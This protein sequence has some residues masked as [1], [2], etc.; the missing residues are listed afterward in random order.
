MQAGGV[1]GLY[2]HWKDRASEAR[3]CG[4][5]G[6]VTQSCHKSC[7][8]TPWPVARQTPLSM[9]FF[10]QEY[11]SGLPFPSPGD[12]PNPGIEPWSPAL[13]ADGLPTK[14]QKRSKKMYSP[15]FE[16]RLS[17]RRSWP[18]GI[19]GSKPAS[20]LTVFPTWKD[21][22]ESA[23]SGGDLWRVRVSSEVVEPP[24]RGGQ[25]DAG[26]ATKTLRSPWAGDSCFVNSSSDTTSV[27]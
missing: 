18:V 10:R 8:A 14:L 4:A 20:F 23:W 24:A 22:W 13:Q 17:P 7:L 12:P 15:W 3:K 9:G 19:W 1:G 26:D 16:T 11:W 27:C 6:L 5:A 25:M 2:S 21:S